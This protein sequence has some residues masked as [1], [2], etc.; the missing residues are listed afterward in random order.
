M[1]EGRAPCPGTV[2]RHAAR[3]PR[4][5]RRRRAA[6]ALCLVAIGRLAAAAE[7]PPESAP[8]FWGDFGVGVGELDASAAPSGASGGGIAAD[9]TV[10]GRLSD[11][12][13]MG[14]NL[15]GIGNRLS[16][17]YYDANDR[18]S[19]VYG[20]TVT[21]VFLTVQF[22]PAGD[23]GWLYG[24]GA[25]QVLYHNHDLEVLTGD[26][27]NGEGAGGELHVGYDWPFPGHAHVEARL[28]VERGHISLSSPLGGSFSFTAVSLSVHIA[29]H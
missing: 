9:L 11:R 4:P 19:S 22:E 15:G 29:H 6:A 26:Y 27:R 20:Q 17:S 1:S 18:Y 25:G 14:L 28:G 2:T 24:A 13:L 16:S 5:R 12:W 7:P 23:A 10:G 3:G 8:R 21:N